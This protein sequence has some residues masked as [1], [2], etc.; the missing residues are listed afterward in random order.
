MLQQ[1]LTWAWQAGQTQGWLGSSSSSGGG[2]PA[3]GGSG[4]VYQDGGG[5]P[6]PGTCGGSRRHRSQDQ[7]DELRYRAAFTPNPVGTVDGVGGITA[8]RPEDFG[9]P[10]PA[11]TSEDMAEVESD[12]PRVGVARRMEIV[13]AS[14]L[15][16][17]FVAGTAAV[18]RPDR[19]QRPRGGA[20]GIARHRRRNPDR[21]RTVSY[22]RSPRERREVR[23]ARAPD[24]DD[25]TL[26]SVIKS[27]LNGYESS[28]SSGSDDLL[29]MDAETRAV[30]G[31][32][33]AAERSGAAVSWSPATP[34]ARS[35]ALPSLAPQAL[36]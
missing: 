23:P 21:D 27:F 22:S 17:A 20:R 36:N 14:A 1:Q 29:A 24:I 34:P 3:P 15:H 30:P 31:S 12:G 32:P 5:A 26:A 11:R 25:D 4:G 6:G 2:A 35:A 7:T 9:T 33:P 19:E 10:L 18:I 28:V 13:L 8:Q 16:A